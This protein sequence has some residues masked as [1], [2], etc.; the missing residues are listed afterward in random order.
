MT[1]WQQ[2][3]VPVAGVLLIALAY[4]SYGWPGVALVAGGIVFWLL[5][6]FTR[7]MTVLRRAAQR[8]IGHVGSAVML[9]ARLKPGLT[10]MHVVALTRALGAQQSPPGGQPELFR[11]TDPGGSWVDCEFAGGKLRRWTLV[12]P[13]EPPQPPQP[14]Q[15]SL[16]AD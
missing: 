3:V 14:P 15:P 16:P 9:N 8:P 7:L 12:R 13:S 10:L 5:L 11:W 1:N 2:I 6:H 4:N